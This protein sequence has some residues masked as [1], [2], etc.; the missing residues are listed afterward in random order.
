M[1]ERND[2]LEELWAA[3]RKIEE[4]NGNNVDTLFENFKVRQAQSPESYF[5]GKPVTIERLKVA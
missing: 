1:D 5:I 4:Q 2:I 3:R